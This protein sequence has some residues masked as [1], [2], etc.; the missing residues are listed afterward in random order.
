[1]ALIV[2]F[3]LKYKF[4]LLK[5]LVNFDFHDCYSLFTCPDIPKHDKDYFRY[6][7]RIKY[8]KNTLCTLQ[9]L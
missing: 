2:D 5:V 4:I 9:S 8:G 1:M 6:R 7:R 3:C